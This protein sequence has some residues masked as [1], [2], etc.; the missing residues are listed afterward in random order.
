MG[1]RRRGLCLD[2]IR[3]MQNLKNMLV[4]EFGM[5]NLAQWS[6]IDATGIS[7][8]G[9]TIVGNGYNPSGNYEAWRVNLDGVTRS[10]M[11]PTGDTS[12]DEPGNWSKWGKPGPQTDVVINPNNSFTV[13]GP[14]APAWIRSLTVGTIQSGVAQLTLDSPY[15]WA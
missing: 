10:W 6:L 13:N 1:Y 12:W 9:L 4:N 8:D 11:S 5:S 7:D 15:T 2:K 3:G 14:A